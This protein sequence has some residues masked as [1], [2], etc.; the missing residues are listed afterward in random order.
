MCDNSCLKSRDD[1][2]TVKQT[3]EHIINKKG[4]C[5][6][7]CI[8]II[9][10]NAWNIYYS[11]EIKLQNLI[12]VSI[13]G[14]SNPFFFSDE[15]VIILI[16]ETCSL[17][18]QDEEIVSR[19]IKDILIRTRKGLIAWLKDG[20]LSVDPNV[21]VHL[22]KSGA[23][24]PS[25]QTNLSRGFQKKSRDSPCSAAVESFSTYSGQSQGDPV[26]NPSVWQSGHTQN[27]PQ[28]TPQAAAANQQMHPPATSKNGEPVLLRTILRYGKVSWELEDLQMWDPDFT[29]PEF[30]SES[31]FQEYQHIPE[32]GVRIVF[33]NN[34]KLKWSVDSKLKEFS[35]K[36]EIQMDK[37]KT[38]C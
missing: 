34:G 18:P 37:M 7:A 5:F 16:C 2:V 20:S 29:V 31:L 27:K 12:D 10:R 13:K 1:E 19:T 15:K 8:V 36:K 9:P 22:L 6:S 11:P 35:R 25:P 38:S 17:P 32:A 33:G 3:I 26:Q 24:Q 23:P 30:I 28:P 4:K 21:M 14:I